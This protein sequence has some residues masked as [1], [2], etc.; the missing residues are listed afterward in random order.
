MLVELN[1]LE[2]Q[3]PNMFLIQLQL[4]LTMFHLN[5]LELQLTQLEETMLLV[6]QLLQIMFQVETMYQE[7][8]EHKSLQ[9]TLLK[10]L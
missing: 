1:L 10:K 8:Q 4:L 2:Q 7:V 5:Q 6:A 3:L 9:I